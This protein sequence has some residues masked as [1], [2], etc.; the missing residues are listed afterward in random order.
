MEARERKLRCQHS[1][2]R[3]DSTCLS[4]DQRDRDSA[5]SDPASRCYTQKMT[6]WMNK[7]YMSC[8][9]CP[10]KNPDLN[11]HEHGWESAVD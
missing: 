11:G 7:Y 5:E 6:G 9:C 2:W 8:C 1:F 4:G 3:V 10:L